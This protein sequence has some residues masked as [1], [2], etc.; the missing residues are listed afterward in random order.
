[1][2]RARRE[3][4]L[5]VIA[6]ALAAVAMGHV[7]CGGGGG[8]PLPP[9]QT[10]SVAVASVAS[11]APDA[12]ALDGDAGSASRAARLAT[13]LF[14]GE[15]ITVDLAPLDERERERE[16]FAALVDAQLSAAPAMM[17]V[18]PVLGALAHAWSRRAEAIVA[19]YLVN[20]DH[21]L[22]E[23]ARLIVRANGLSSAAI[24]VAVLPKEPDPDA[25]ANV[26]DAAS[27]APDASVASLEHLCRSIPAGSDADWTCTAALTRLGSTAARA[28]LA[29]KTRASCATARPAEVIARFTWLAAEV[30]TRGPWRE[31][32]EQIRNTRAMPIVLCV[33]NFDARS[34][35]GCKTVGHYSPIGDAFLRE[36]VG[37]YGLK[38]SFPLDGTGKTFTSAQ[39]AEVL[40]LLAA[41]SSPQP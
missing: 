21:G 37:L 41:S 8:K 6:S 10:A 7:A 26:V 5:A 22:A 9:P 34:D 16:D 1:M 39:R 23:H 32:G 27:R 15:S 3:T 20:A 25:R 40:R 18:R 33:D 4:Q 14:L 28:A 11:S 17:P 30:G 31:L 12:A 13:R 2:W 36:V 19:R 29:A 35:S 38:V 24:A